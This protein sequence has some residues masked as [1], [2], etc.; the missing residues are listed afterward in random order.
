MH[1][2]SGH[3]DALAPQKSVK[4]DQQLSVLDIVPGLP[5]RQIAPGPCYKVL[6]LSIALPQLQHFL[7]ATRRALLYCGGRGYG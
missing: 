7:L 1:R 6:E 5:T 4:V 2:C 3:A